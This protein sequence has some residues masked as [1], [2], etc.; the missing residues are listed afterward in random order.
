MAHT[1]AHDSARELRI[2]IDG[3]H[4]GCDIG[5][6]I[7]LAAITAEHAHQERVA[8]HPDSGSPAC[9][10]YADGVLLAVARVVGA[11]FR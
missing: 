5:L 9:R 10:V 11:R 3:F 2:Y 4:A 1:L 7:A 8:R 6:A